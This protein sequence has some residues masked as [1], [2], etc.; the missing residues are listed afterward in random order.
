[1]QG[2]WAKSHRT[3]HGYL[4]AASGSVSMTMCRKLRELPFKFVLNQ[5][6]VLEKSRAVTR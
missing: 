4:S 2:P 1:M 5:I 3:K 6:T